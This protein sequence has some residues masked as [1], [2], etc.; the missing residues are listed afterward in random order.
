[1]WFGGVRWAGEEGT[2]ISLLFVFADLKGGREFEC[3]GLKR[4]RKFFFLLAI[5]ALSIVDLG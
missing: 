2:A 3:R 1:M 4:G 5:A